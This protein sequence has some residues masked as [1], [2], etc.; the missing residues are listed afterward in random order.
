[1]YIFIIADRAKQIQNYARVNTE[2]TEKIIRE[3]KEENDKL[4]RLLERE[5]LST[6][7]TAATS[8]YYGKFFKIHVLEFTLIFDV[9]QDETKAKL[10]EEIEAI[11]HENEKKL[12]ELRQ[13]YEE[14]LIQ[15]RNI[16][17]SFTDKEYLLTQREYDKQFNPYLSNLN[18]DEQLM[19]KIIFILKP[20]LNTIGK[21][22]SCTITLYGPLI[23][24]KHATINRTERNKIILERID[25][26]CK[27]LLNGDPVVHKVNLTHNDR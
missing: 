3:L 18:F 4:R 17:S 21:D 8:P 7:D 1:M 11:M 20:G 6:A 5:T 22:S 24:D 2:S 13:S 15:E 12:F 16:H 14:R 26:D 25:E 27:I 19:G 9:F 23:M 10:E